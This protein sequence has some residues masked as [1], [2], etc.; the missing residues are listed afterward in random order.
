MQSSF[1]II[2]FKKKNKYVLTI[3]IFF[4]LYVNEVHDEK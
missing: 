4:L 3:I 1:R 2:K